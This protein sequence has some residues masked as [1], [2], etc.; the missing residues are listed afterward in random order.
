[1]LCTTI[2]G[3]SFLEAKKQILRSLKE[4]HCFEMR[5]DLLSVSCLELKKLMELAPISILAWKKP[6]SC[7]QADWIDKMQSLAELNPNYLD[8]EKDFPEEDMIRIR[9]LHPQ[10]KIIRSL[11]TS[12]HTDII[13]LYAHMRSSAADYY[14]FAVSS[15]STTDLL[16][17]C[18]QKRSLPENTTVVCLGGM[19]RPSRILSPILQNPFTYARSTGSSPVA[20]GQFSLKHHY[21]YNFASLSAQSPICALIGDTSRSIG[22][23]THNPFFSQ[24]GVACP[25][26]KLPLTPQE[27]PKFFSTIRTQPFLGVSVTSPLKTAVLPF[28][29][30]QAPSVKASGSCNTL[31]IRQGEIEG[32]DTDGEGLFSVL[33]QHQIPLNNQRVAIIGAGGAAQSIATRLSRANCELLIFNR[34]KAHAED[35]ASRCQA[36][37]FSLEEL[38]LHRVSLII[39]CLPPSCTIPKAVAPCVVD[40]NTI[41]KHSTFTQYARSQGSSIIYGHE[42]FTQQALLQFRLWFPKLSFKHLEK[43]FIRRAAVLASLFSIAP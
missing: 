43:T 32:H 20:P 25:Y 12:E 10:I 7:S 40:I 2:S 4:C 14:K 18:H 42:M 22:H 27:L 13:Q 19:G 21:F 30:K 15:S 36:K 26:I 38:P 29:D 8:L 34:T 41:P 5:V 6:E 17:I 23:L 28:L 33:M 31:V 39:N 16:D 1:M 35:L 37:A 11:H 3:P 9:Q 24:L